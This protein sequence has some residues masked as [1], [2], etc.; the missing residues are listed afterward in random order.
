MLIYLCDIKFTYNSCEYIRCYYD[1]VKK[2]FH[3]SSDISMNKSFTYDISTNTWCT[4]ITL[5]V[6][7]S[8][9]NIVLYD[10]G[11]MFNKELNAKIIEC[12]NNE[13]LKHIFNNV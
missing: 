2:C 6:S 5:D 1:S 12:C 13:L 4:V 11:D 3:I 8:V 10:I 7:E 9:D